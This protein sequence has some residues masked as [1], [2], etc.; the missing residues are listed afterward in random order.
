MKN[1]KSIIFKR[2]QAI[3]KLLKEATEIHVETL[4]EKLNVSSTTIRRDLQMFEKQHIVNRFH[5]G[6]SLI[7]D[8]SKEDPSLE[9]QSAKSL[10]EKTLSPDMLPHLL[11]MATLYL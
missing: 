9:P 10:S 3:L 8:S 4:A 2:Q 5:G 1:S 6:A 7:R 11:T